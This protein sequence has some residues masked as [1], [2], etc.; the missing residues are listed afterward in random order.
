MSATT[1]K[2]YRY[3]KAFLR[4][5]LDDGSLLFNVEDHSTYTLNHTAAYIIQQIIRKVPLPEVADRLSAGYGVSRTVAGKDCA[6]LIA[7]LKKRGVIHDTQ[8][9]K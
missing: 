4:A 6:R 8:S 1:N 3:N 7:E 9:K 5:D 2:R